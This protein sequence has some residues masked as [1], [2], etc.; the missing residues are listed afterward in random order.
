MENPL[1]KRKKEMENTLTKKRKDEMNGKHTD[2][3]DQRI[4]KHIAPFHLALCHTDM[5]RQD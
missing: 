2:K 4:I 5:L 1:T 3:E